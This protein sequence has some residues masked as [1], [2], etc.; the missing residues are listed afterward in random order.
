MPFPK[1]RML[2][3]SLQLINPS[4]LKQRKKMKSWDQMEL[5]P[6]RSPISNRTSYL[7]FLSNRSKKKLRSWG[8]TQAS[9][10]QGPQVG[11][12]LSDCLTRSTLHLSKWGHLKAHTKGKSWVPQVSSVAKVATS[13]NTSSVLTIRT[14]YNLR[15]RSFG[16]QVRPNSKST[17]TACWERS[18]TCTRLN[19]RRS[20]REC[21]TWLV[22][23][24]KT[25]RKRDLTPQLCF[26]PLNSSSQ[27]ASLECTTSKLK[28]RKTNGSKQSRKW[29]DTPTS[30]T[31]TRS[32]T[33]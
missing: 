25:K 1:L 6:F 11:T 32:G 4:K 2:F 31:T 28:I 5:S 27:E 15:A 9:M 20:T 17:G 10:P 21:T 29:L 33:L 3:W 30:T 24:Y 26:T 13:L 19:Q 12:S 18:C 7:S 23:S 8:A 22:S 16:K 14:L